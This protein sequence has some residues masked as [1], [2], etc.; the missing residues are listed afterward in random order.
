[1]EIWM[2]GVCEYGTV[3]SSNLMVVFLSSIMGAFVVTLKSFG[4]ILLLIPCKIMVS[5]AVV[6]VTPVVVKRGWSP[7]ICTIALS[8]AVGK[9]PGFNRAWVICETPFDIISIVG[10][11][12]VAT[13]L[14][15]LVTGLMSLSTSS[16]V[17]PAG[18]WQQAPKRNPS[19]QAPTTCP[20]L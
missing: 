15:M 1:M 12:G 6:C 2:V 16:P 3:V 18:N 11:V 9:I 20:F 14:L 4:L 17:S 8:C 19:I 13:S 5:G 10:S 7:L